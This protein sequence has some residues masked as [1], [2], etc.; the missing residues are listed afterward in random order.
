MRLNSGLDV[1]DLKQWNGCMGLNS[2]LDGCDL[3]SGL[4]VRDKE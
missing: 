4:D 3:N 1:C 2:G